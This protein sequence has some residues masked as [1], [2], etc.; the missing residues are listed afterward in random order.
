MI[1]NYFLIIHQSPRFYTFSI[2]G[3]FFSAPGQTFLISLAIPTICHSLNISPLQFASIYSL[4]T[5][6]ASLFLPFIGKLIDRWPIKKTLIFNAFF[7]FSS[8]LLFSLSASS[9]GLFVALFFMR[10]F[11]QGALTLTATSHTIKQFTLNRGSAL[12]LTQLGYPLSEFIFPGLLIFSLHHIGFRLSFVALALCIPLLYLP[13]SLFGISKMPSS[14]HAPDDQP[15][16]S[17]SLSYAL[18]DRFFPFYVALS[19]IPPIMM[20]AALYFQVDIFSSNGWPIA[21]A[22]IAIFCYAFFKFL[23]TLLIGPVIDRFGVVLP[24]FFLTFCIG[25]ATFLISFNG[26]P[27]MAFIYYSL[28]GLG[29]GAS[30]STMSYLWALL[31]GSR[32][33]GEIKG[34]IAI[35]RNGATAIAPILFSFFLYERQLPFQMIFQ[36]CGIGILIMSILPFVFKQLDHRLT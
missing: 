23:N 11:G 29:L 21:N 4:S 12:S 33:I 17:H 6:M 3:I 35:I 18:K 31:Y 19:S 27:L 13:L 10:L 8:I 16:H 36:I 26:P 32:Y 30:A 28:Y 15:E 1:R 5:L 14:H 24:L 34:S 7:F 25:L 9:Y 20:T 2:F 22:A